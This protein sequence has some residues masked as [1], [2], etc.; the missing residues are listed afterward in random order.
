MLEILEP[1]WI[2]DGKG[3]QH[4]INDFPISQKDTSSNLTG[5]WR[6]L[7]PFF[8]E[9]VA[10]C[11]HA[12]P[13]HT[14]IPTYMN[15]VSEGNLSEALEI[16]RQENPLP[17][18]CGRVCPHF[19]EESC[20]RSKFDDR[21]SIRAIERYIGDY[22][23]DIPHKKMR[24]SVEAN[25]AVVGSGPAGLSAAYFL[26]REGVKVDLYERETKPGGLLRYGI[27]EYRLPRDILDRE[28]ENIL[29]LGVTFLKETDVSP[30]QI[31][32][33]SERYNFVFL[34]PGLWGRNMLGWDYEGEAVFDGLHLLRDINQGKSPPLGER[35]AVVGGGNTAFDVSRVLLRLGKKVTIVYRRSLVEAPA[36]AD[37]I[38]EAM[39]ENIHIMERKLIT[40]IEDQKDGSLRVEIEGAIK[41]QDGKIGPDGKKVQRMVDNV[42]AAVGQVAEIKIE[43]NDKIICGGDYETGEGTVAHA[44]ASGKRG[45]FVIL[46][47]LGVLGAEPSQVNPAFSTDSAASKTV[48]YKELNLSFV[49]NS[50]RL[51]PEKKAAMMRIS[52]FLEVA[53]SLSQ[54]DV[55]SESSRCLSCGTCTLCGTCWYFC[56]DACVFTG[57][58][59]GKKVDFNRDFCKGCAVCSVVCPRGCIVMMEEGE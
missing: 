42:I 14:N 41:G 20:N 40:R 1:S 8:Q 52:G 6:T 35:I 2:S 43:K 51:E 46:K 15:L 17:A 38:E 44:I 26:A 27:P 22:G 59:G 7:I 4:N 57:Q 47:K 5:S 48:S 21:L 28:I 19:C 50:R 16:I 36:F 49:R 11:C 56:P 34:S 29:T 18:V 45:A 10:P 54:E 53:S 31:G 13:N 58:E 30:D 25:V 33:L 3:P 37:E 23:L 12:C 9:G 24:H 32:S 55:L 39:E